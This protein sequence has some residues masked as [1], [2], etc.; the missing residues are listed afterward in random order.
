LPL[1]FVLPFVVFL[2]DGPGAAE[3]EGEEEGEEEDEA[4]DLSSFFLS[5]FI[6]M[7]LQ[8]PVPWNSS[9]APAA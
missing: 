5:R 1:P 8:T 2:A 3:E 6:L 4:E 9:V 7:P